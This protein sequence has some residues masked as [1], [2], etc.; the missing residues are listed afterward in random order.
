M[1]GCEC[2]SALYFL[3]MVRL[4]PDKLSFDQSIANFPAMES[5]NPLFPSNT[6]DGPVIPPLARKAAW[7]PQKAVFG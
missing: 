3:M 5:K 2:I 1:E 4:T 7:V 6:S